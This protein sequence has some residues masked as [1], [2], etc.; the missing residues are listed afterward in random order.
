MA[1][2]VANPRRNGAAIE[3]L[4]SLE[5]IKRMKCAW[6]IGEASGRG[7][8]PAKV[9]AG[10]SAEKTGADQEGFLRCCR[11]DAR[12]WRWSK[13]HSSGPAVWHGEHGQRTAA[14]T[15]ER[16]LLCMALR[17]FPSCHE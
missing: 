15:L 13:M 16:G 4:P 2:A 17:G 14:V 3:L 8:G 1:G 7:L 11:R 10:R 9:N 6:D 12:Y 5:R